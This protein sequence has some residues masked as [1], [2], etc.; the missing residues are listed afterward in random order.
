MFRRKPSRVLALLT[1]LLA[2][3]LVVAA[4]GGGQQSQQPQEPAEGG[5]TPQEPSGP[6][7]VTIAQFTAPNQV[8]HPQLTQSA[9][10]SDIA[11]LIF[12]PVL[13]FTEDLAFEPNLAEYEISED[14]LSVTFR[15]KE[16]LV[17]SDGTPL[18][19]ADYAFTYLN[20]MHPEWPG[21]SQSIVASLRGGQELLNKYNELRN[22]IEPENPE[23]R[24]EG[25]DYIT[26]EEFVEQALPL[27]EEWLATNPIETPDELTAIVH[28]DDVYAP[29]LQTF[30][31]ALI[32][33]HIYEGIPVRDWAIAEVTKKPPVASGPYKF[34]QYVTDQF[35]ELEANESYHKGRP[36]IDKIIFRVVDAEVAIGELQN[37]TI[38]AV[39]V[40][41]SQISPQ[42]FEEVIKNFSH[43]DWWENPQFGYQHMFINLTHP[44][45]QIKEVRQAMA[46]AI[47]RQGIVDRLLFGHG[48]VMNT[49][50]L[51]VQWAYDE[52]GVNP[53]PY[54]PEKAKE[55]LAQAGFQ[56][57]DG[58]GVLEK[59]GQRLEFS[60][61]Y[62]GGTSNPVR[63]ASAPLIQQYLGAV[64]IK[65]NLE[66]L[67]FNTVVAKAT[68]VPGQRPDYD[69]GLLG[70]SVT[71]D[72]DQTGLWGPNDP[73]N[74]TVFS[75][76]TIGPDY[77]RAMEL[78]E[79]GLRTFDQ[80]ERTAIY[81]E[82]GRIFNEHLPYVFLYTANDITVFNK[83][84]QNVNRDIRG[85][86]FNVHEWT[87]AE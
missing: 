57:T 5:E 66:P 28:F 11:G 20:Q 83:R 86:L 73:Y 43:V 77:D 82:L 40:G 7:Q 69:L 12:E 38:D 55:L 33:K 79:Q 87:L 78:I 41:A 42:D 48:T 25:V 76:E 51:P 16:G 17:W 63:Q 64:G 81:K 74:F 85:A 50:F 10:D 27:Y 4:C 46:Y 24:Q 26:Y 39:G 3:A 56:D 34:V 29:A 71:V 1:A 19:S 62:P 49:P 44:L 60:L 9:Y 67:E 30:G 80:A 13:Q 54:D 68:Y 58:D 47:D 84:V 61:V 18:T 75:T 52:S 36:N 14:Q 37:G 22:R 6:T 65:I 31:G 21:P 2:V 53:Y 72:P 59:D 23:D 15:F 8:F 35:T 32:P 70:W 45:L